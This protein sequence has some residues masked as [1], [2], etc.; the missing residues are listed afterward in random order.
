MSLF[1]ELKRRNVIRMAGLYLVGAWLIVQIAGTV[2][3]MFGAPAW[4]PRSIVVLLALGFAPALVFSWVYELTPE[5]LK[6]DAEVP[7]E[8]SI[9]TQTGRR[10]DRLIIIGLLAVVALVAADRFWP[11]A[12]EREGASANP[13]AN[14]H[15]RT[16]AVLPFINLSGDPTQEFFSDGI[17]EEI[18]NVL[19]SIEAFTVTSRTSSFHFKGKDDPLPEIARELHVDYVLE[20][21]VRKAG[22][23]VRIT[24]QLIKVDGDAHMWSES[25]TRDVADIFAVQEGIARNVASEL[26]ARLTERD[27]ARLTRTGT[28]NATAYEDYLHGRELWN[29]RS[30]ASLQAAV[31]AFN[32]AVSGDPDYAAAWAGLA[33]TY[34]LIPEYSAFER[35]ERSIIDTV[36][37]ARE[38]AERALALDPASSRA[39]SARAY[40][41]VMYA[42]DWQGAEADYRAAIASDPRDAGIHQWYGE[43]LAYQRRWKESAAQYDAAVALDPLAP[44]IYQSRGVLYLMGGDSA[45]ALSNLDEALRL[46][47]GFSFAAH[48]KTL[49]LIDL[50]RFDDAAVAARDLPDDDREMMS[51]IIAAVQ[52]P[53]RSDDAVRQIMAHDADSIPG[54]PFSLAMIGRRDLALAELERLFAMDDPYRSFTYCVSAFDPLHADPRFQ[55]LLRQIGLPASKDGSDTDRP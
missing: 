5:G 13:R 26:E 12:A 39:L 1:T 48:L 25:W 20:G 3:P 43:L 24:A 30:L 42:F 10:M 51:S 23:Q 55:A 37:L 41:G 52:D 28:R 7:P 33:Q 15:T 19:A 17:T 14:T 34:A 16:I 29:E 54:R 11:R 44:I 35:G 46:V 18:L 6:R 4:L 49:A 45:A 2:L 22:Q 27:E 9:G 32:D 40:V 36:A 38:A 47:P 8:R 21:S 50:R 31:D 53:S